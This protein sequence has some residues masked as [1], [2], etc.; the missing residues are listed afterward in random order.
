MG[1]CVPGGRLP[2]A[3]DTRR[4]RGAFLTTSSG[5]SAHGPLQATQDC[6]EQPVWGTQ[7]TPSTLPS[8]MAMRSAILKP[9]GLNLLVHRHIVAWARQRHGAGSYAGERSAGPSGP[10]FAAAAPAAYEAGSQAATRY[11]G[12]G[13]DG[14]RWGWRRPLPGAQPRRQGLS[15]CRAAPRCRMCLSQAFDVM[16]SLPPSA[17]AAAC[18]LTPEALAPPAWCLG[19][20]WAS[21]PTRTPPPSSGHTRRR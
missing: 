6:Q 10:P 14:G 7:S 19:R 17:A 5:T 1:G 11:G 15:P 20:S 9:R 8:C 13:L 2:A 16:W 3:R 12:A 21:H 4:T 18:R